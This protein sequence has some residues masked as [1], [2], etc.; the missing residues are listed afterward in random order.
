[1]GARIKIPEKAGLSKRQPL[2]GDF[3]WPEIG[4][5]L[6]AGGSA[7]KDGGVDAAEI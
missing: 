4:R 1:M 2:A 7:N 6:A 5:L 3:L